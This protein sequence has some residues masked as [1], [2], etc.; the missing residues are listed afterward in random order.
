[1][2]ECW[3]DGCTEPVNPGGHSGWGAIVKDRENLLLSS[4]GYVGF[5]PEMSNNVAEYAG[6]IAILKF[7][8]ENKISEA[9]IFGDSDLVVKQL[10]GQWK[11][12]RGLYLPYF[13][14][15][16]KL[17]QQLPLVTLHW[18]PRERNDAADKLSKQGAKQRY[19]SRRKPKIIKKELRELIKA[20]RDDTRDNRLRW[21]HAIQGR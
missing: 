3:F 11:A 14:E 18:I 9:R 8:I 6:V 17:K 2:I 20:Q 19:P 10:M 1:M 5:G 15:A 21:E 7:L 4:C 13:K 12:K 16:W